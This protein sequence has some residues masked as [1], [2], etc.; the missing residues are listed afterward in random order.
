MAQTVCV[1]LTDTEKARL[2][3][4]SEDRARSSTSSAPVSSCSQPNACPS[5]M[6]PTR[7]ASAEPPSGAGSSATPRR[8]STACCTTRPARP[9]SRPTPPAPSPRC[10]RSPAPSRPAR[11]PTEPVAPSRRQPASRCAPSSASGRSTVCSP[12]GCAPSSAPPTPPPPRRCGTS[13]GSTSRR[14]TGR[15]C[16]AWTRSPMCGWP[17]ARKQKVDGERRAC[18]HVSG[19]LERR[20]RPLATMDVRGL[21]PHQILGFKALHFS[22]MTQL[23]GATDPSITFISC[24]RHVASS[25]PRLR[26][27]QPAD[28]TLLASSPPRRSEPSC[29]P[30]PRQPS[31]ARS[32]PVSGR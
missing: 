19:L 23:V 22:R 9:A 3:A 16:S 25:A 28:S 13:W 15:W 8:A 7:P 6:S 17:P 20:T 5:W 1:I 29:W 26:R 4:I 21:G 30:T 14:L 18:G 2:R 12:T 11:S 31:G 27:P 32:G 24:K 10:W